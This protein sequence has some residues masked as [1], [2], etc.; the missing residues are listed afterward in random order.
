M[1]FPIKICKIDAYREGNSLKSKRMK[2]ES[3][4]YEN[5]FVKYESE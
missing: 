4:F 1:S 3:A 5:N 2:R